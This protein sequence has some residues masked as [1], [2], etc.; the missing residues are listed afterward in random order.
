MY[1][2]E[3]IAIT[4]LRT[5]CVFIS[6]TCPA[7]ERMRFLSAVNILFGR[8][9][10]SI[11]RLPAVKSC[12]SSERAKGSDVDLLVIWQTIK[13]SPGRSAITKAGRFLLPERSVNGNG[14]ITT[15]PFTNLPMLHLLQAYSSLLTKTLRSSALSPGFGTFYA[16]LSMIQN[17][18]LRQHM[19]SEV[20]LFLLIKE[21]VLSWFSPLN[22]HEVNIA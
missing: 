3:M 21:H 8:M 18:S 15:S 9:K 16:V 4:A 22:G 7:A 11:G 1:Q 2:E 19:L 12:A 13:S 14:I 20:F 5:A 6:D 17:Q 10:L